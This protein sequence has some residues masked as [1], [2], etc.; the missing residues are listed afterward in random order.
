MKTSTKMTGPFFTHDPV[1]TFKANC[2][3]MLYSI[4]DAGLVDVVH[5]L[6]NGE[7]GRAP[8]KKLGDRVSEHVTAGM[9]ARRPAPPIATVY[10]RNEGFSAAEA[11]SLMAASSRVEGRTH[12]FRKVAGRLKRSREAN[13]EELLKGI[14]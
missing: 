6:Q 3:T 1:R 5:E 8:I 4:I 11:I 9:K 10:V 2:S 14:A 13:W 12:A 7:S